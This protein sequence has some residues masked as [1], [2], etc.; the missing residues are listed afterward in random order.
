MFLTSA[1][2]SVSIALYIKVTTIAG[3]VSV[4]SSHSTFAKRMCVRLIKVGLNAMEYIVR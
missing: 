1:L 4:G 3:S 2:M